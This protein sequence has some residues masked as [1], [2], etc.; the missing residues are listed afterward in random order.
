LKRIY[1]Q[2]NGSLGDLLSLLEND[3]DLKELAGVVSYFREQ[4]NKL[5]HVVGYRSSNSRALST[6]NMTKELLKTIV[7]RKI[8]K[9]KKT[10]LPL[11]K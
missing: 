9:L 4:V 8:I 1:K 7:Y 2:N 3:N 11:V 5:K 10:T 6:F